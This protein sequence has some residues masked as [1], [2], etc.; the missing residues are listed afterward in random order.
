MTLDRAAKYF[1]CEKEDFFHWNDIGV[2]K[3]SIIFDDYQGNLLT[4]NDKRYELR[5][6]LSE[7]DFSEL[8]IDYRDESSFFVIESTLYDS[9]AG[10]HRLTGFAGGVWTPCSSVI[11]YLSKGD[12]PL[13]SG[14]AASPYYNENY[15]A[16]INIKNIGN[17][18]DVNAYS[19][20]NITVDSLVLFKDDLEKI[21][22]LLNN[23]DNNMDN[24]KESKLNLDDSLLIIGSILSAL[25]KVEPTSKRWT[26]EALT[27]EILDATP[28]T[29]I[30]K[31]AIDD[32][33][34]E[35]NK[36]FKSKK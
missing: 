34:S 1:K 4:I 8:N 32:Y 3:L 20:P 25:K 2:I 18:D 15:R 35:A 10:I 9:L 31:R 16:F 33:F 6:D 17:F 14:F 5:E 22:I 11:E 19:I 24:E 27:R 28:T 12:S 7:D 30:S 13:N 26:Q 29:S 36:R 21:Q 23:E